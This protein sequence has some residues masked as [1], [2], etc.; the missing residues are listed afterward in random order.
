MVV[1]HTIY[2]LEYVMHN[3]SET[4][5]K[6]IMYDVYSWQILSSVQPN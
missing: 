5:L 1:N 3:K 2:Y 4:K 6:R